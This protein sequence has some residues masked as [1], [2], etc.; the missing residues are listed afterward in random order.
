MEDFPLTEKLPLRTTPAFRTSYRP[1]PTT[2]PDHQNNCVR[3]WRRANLNGD[4]DAAFG[5]TWGDA[6]VDLQNS[7]HESGGG[8]GVEYLGGLA[9]DENLHW[10]K[11]FW[12]S[13][14]RSAFP[15][16]PR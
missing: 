11:R 6:G 8:S 16:S 7:L 9:V 2:S 3:A 13:Q 4:R 5:G 1:P 15:A 10:K 14:V 12:L